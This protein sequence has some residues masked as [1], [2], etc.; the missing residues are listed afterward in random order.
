MPDTNYQKLMAN[1]L[2]EIA[3][4]RTQLTESDR[5]KKEP[6][7]IVG[8]GCRFP[9]G[10]NNVDDYWKLL[11]EGR[12][13]VARMN[14][15]RWDMD[16]G[17]DPDPAAPGKISSRYMGMLDKVDQFDADLFGI[18]PVEAQCMDPQHRIF[19]ET[20]WEALEHA[21]YAPDSL[22]GSKT[23][24]FLGISGQ[25]YAHLQT[26]KKLLD[27]I[28]PYDGT[29]NSSSVAAG[30]LSYLL[31]LT[32]PALAID[33]ACSSSLVVMNNAC[34][35]LR[36]RETNM[37]IAGGSHLILC[38]T[39]SI[40]FSKA[41]MLAEDGRCK[42]FDADANGYVRAE[43]CGVVILKRLSD[44]VKDGDNILALIRGTA[45][46]QDGRSQG[47][48]APNE[49]AQKSVIL[50]ALSNAGVAKKHVSYVE[51]HG[52]G[53][54]LGDP[55]EVDALGSVYSESHS[56]EQPLLIGSAKTN[57]GHMETAAGIGGIIKVVLSMQHRTLPA[58]QNYKTPNPHIQWDQYPIEVCSKKR[59]WKGYGKDSS[60]LIAGVSSFGFGGTNGHVILQSTPKFP[61]KKNEHEPDTH[62]VNLSGKS[63]KA[64]KELAERYQHFLVENPETSLANFAYT[65]RVGRNQF[66]H[67]ASIVA[68]S[69]SQLGEALSDF[70][71]N[72]KNENLVLGNPTTNNKKIAFFFSGQGSQYP[73][74]GKSLYDTQPKFRKTMDQCA[75]LLASHLPQPLFSVMWGDKTELLS[76]TQYTQPAL[77]AI[78][79]SLATL[80]R[81]WGIQPAKMLG[82]SVGEYAAACI[83]GIFTLE[84]A[85]K[86][87][88]ARGRLMTEL[89]TPGSMIVI[90]APEIAVQQSLIGLEDLV[91]I[92]AINGPSSVAV[93]GDNKT[94]E[95]LKL[96]FESQGIK[97]QPLTVSHAFHSPLMTPMLHAFS[98][99]AHSVEYRKPKVR[100]V[101]TL[102]G[103]QVK[104]EMSNADYWV[105]HIAAPVRFHKAV[106]S[107]YASDAPA[108]VIEIGPHTTLVGLASTF[109][110]DNTLWI[111]SLRKGKGD[112]PTLLNSIAKL[113]NTGLSIDWIKVENGYTRQRIALPTYPF[114][115]KT[116]WL[117][118]I[119]LGGPPD[120]KDQD[121]LDWIYDIDWKETKLP[122]VDTVETSGNFTNKKWLVMSSGNTL[123][124]DVCQKISDAGAEVVN[125]LFSD[126][127]EVS[128]ATQ[129]QLNPT[130]EDHFERLLYKLDE[131]IHLFEGI[132][133]IADDKQLIPV[134]NASAK[135][136]LSQQEKL[137]GGL[138]YLVQ[139]ITNTIANQLPKL[140]V[141]GDNTENAPLISLYQ[142]PLLG[143]T[144]VVA[145]EYHEL[146]CSSIAIS[147]P[148]A[149]HQL[150]QEIST[151]TREDQICYHN[152]TRSVARLK[153][154]DQNGTTFPHAS[155]KNDKTYLITG[156][157]GGLGLLFA[158]WLVQQGATSLSL[159]G[160]RG[161]TTEDQKSAIAALEATGARIQIVQLDISDAAAVNQLVCQINSTDK[162]LIGVIHTAG[163]L[164]DGVIAQQKWSRF[165]KVFQPKVVGT[166]NLHE[167]T[168]DLAL[169]HFILFSS[170]ASIL[171]L[172]G[173]SNYSAANTFLD[174]FAEYRRQLSQPVL[175]INWGPWSQTGMANKAVRNRLA[176][177]TGIGSIPSEQGIAIFN[178]LIDSGL[179]QVAVVP[180]DWSQIG[181]MFAMA[182]TTP[183]LLID[184][185][186]AK[187][188]GGGDGLDLSDDEL[189]SGGE[190]KHQL[191]DALPAERKKI[192][193]SYV[194]DQVINV[195][196]L[197]GTED[198]DVGIDTLQ[199]LHELG[200]DSLMAVEIRNVL[201]KAIS[202]S[203]PVGLLFD[204]PS[205]S[206]LAG[207]LD[208]QLKIESAS[209]A[210]ANAVENSTVTT[211][212]PND[213]TDDVDNDT[214]TNIMKHEISE[215][216][217]EL[218]NAVAIIGMACRYPG[219]ST[220]PAAFWDLLKNG[221]DGVEDLGDKRW[222]LDEYYDPDPAAPGKVYSR[223][224]GLIDDIDLFDN[225][226]F[227]IAPIEATSMDPQQRLLLETS[228]EAIEYAGYSPAS[229]SGN[230]GGVFVGAGPNE[231]GQQ[232]MTLA[233]PALIN[234]YLGTGNSLSIAAG[235]ISYVL[236]W[237][238]PCAAVDTACSS[239]LVSVHMACQSL[240]LGESD[241]AIAGGVNLT[242]SSLTNI[243]LSRAQ[244]LSADG[245]CKTF[246]KS[247]NGYV[248]SEGCGIVLLKRLK[249]AI[250][251]NDNILAVV[252]GSAINQDGRS[253]GLTAPNGP[254]QETV[255]STALKRAKV[256]AADIEY[257]EAH[258]TGT[259]LGD[260]IEMRSINSVY[261]KAKNRTTPLSVGSVKTNLGHTEVAAGAAGLIKIILSMKNGFIP[262]HLHLQE[263]S[264][265]LEF[266]KQKITIPTVLTPWNT[267]KKKRLAAISSF[268]FSGT[269][270]H[271][272][273]EEGPLRRA[274]INDVD[275]THHILTL[276]GKNEEALNAQVR[277]FQR[278]LQSNKGLDIADICY[279]ANVGRNHFSHRAAFVSDSQENLLSQ[280]EAFSL[281][282]HSKFKKL[283]G[284]VLFLFSG[285]GS[286]YPDMGK[287][288]YETH[289]QFRE[290]M[291]LCESLLEPHLDQSLLSVLWGEN[292]ALL[293]QTQY[294]QPALFAIEYSLAMLWRS[295]GV[296][297]DVLMGHSVGEYAAACIAGVFTLQD[298][299][300]MIAA[301]GRL[302]QQLPDNGSMIA[303]IAEIETVEKVIAPFASQVSIAAYNGP[304]QI[305]VSGE[306]TALVSITENLKSNGIEVIQL[307]VS[308]AFHS[309]LMEPMMQGFESVVRSV[310]FNKPRVG[311][312]SNL[313]G[314]RST[315]ELCNPQY[316][317]DHVRQ[318]VCFLQGMRTVERLKCS[319]LIEVGPRPTLLGMG[320]NCIPDLD[321]TWLPSLR[322]GHPEWKQ[323]LSAVSNMYQHG[324]DF[325]WTAFES[326]YQ[327]N[328]VVLPTYPFQRSR[329]WMGG[330]KSS[331]ISPMKRYKFPM[332]GERL[333]LPG[334][335]QVRFESTYTTS[336]PAYVTDH[337]LFGSV[338]VPGASHISLMLSAAN[339]AFGSSQC[340]L[341]DVCFLQP[342]VP[343][344]D[345]ARNVQLI[346]EIKDE[347]IAYSELMSIG[348]DEDPSDQNRWVVHATG[349]IHY[350]VNYDSIDGQLP[351]DEIKSE[352]SP[353]ITGE[354]FYSIFTDLGYN[355]GESFQWLGDGWYNGSRAVRELRWP[356]LPDAVKDYQLY[357]TLVD[358]FFQSLASCQPDGNEE[359]I[360]NSGNADEI[361]IPF[362]LER[363]KLYRKPE[364]GERLW[365]HSTLRDQVNKDHETQTG[366]VQL[367]DEN[368]KLV[369][370]VVAI[371]TRKASRAALQQGLNKDVVNDWLYQPRWHTKGNDNALPV[372]L[373]RKD[374]ASWLV[375]GKN[376]ASANK[377][378]HKFIAELMT[379]IESNALNVVFV[380]N[381][382]CYEQISTLRYQLSLEN[383][384]QIQQ[385]LSDLYGDS[386]SHCLGVINL[387]G[388]TEDNNID[389]LAALQNEQK[390]T[391]ESSIHVIQALSLM[392]WSK[393]PQLWLGTSNAY[394][395]EGDEQPPHVGQAALWGLGRVIAMEHA[396]LKCTRFDVDLQ[397]N[398]ES[399]KLDLDILIKDLLV[400]DN[401]DQ[402]AIRRGVRHVARLESTME[403]RH[404]GVHPIPA[405]EAYRVNVPSDGVLDNLS[406]D[407]AERIAP[408]AEEVE[409]RVHATALNFRDV[410]NALGMF[411]EFAERTGA[412]IQTTLPLGFDCAGEIV[413]IGKDVTNVKVGDTVLA[414]TMGSL[415]SHVVTHQ[416]FTVKKP[417]NISFAEAAAIPTVFL[418]VYY[419]LKTL[420]KIKKGDRVLIHACAGGVG[421]AA[422]QVAQHLGAEVFATASPGKW[423][424]LRAQGVKHIM[425][426]RTLEFADEI[427]T[428][429]NGEGVDIV[430]NS[431][432][433]ECIPKSLDLLSENGR[434]VEIGK[435]D[436]WSK[437]Q[438]VE[439]RPDVNYFV[440]DL[441]EIFISQPKLLALLLQE[442]ANDYQEGILKPLPLQSFPMHNVSS[443]FR[444][445]AQ[446][447]NIG[448]VV[449]TNPQEQQQPAIN[450]SDNS[451]YLI[452]GGLGALGLTV[453]ESLVKQGARH[454]VL[455]GR[456]SPSNDAQRQILRLET[457]GATVSV[458]NADIADE[459]N[460]RTLIGRFGKDFP[461]LGGIVHAAGVLDDGMI[462][463]QNWSRFETV[464]APKMLGAWHLH[465]QTE[466]QHSTQPLDFF[467]TFSSIASLMGSP[468]Q[469]NYAAANAFLDGLMTYR[470]SIGL[471]G[472][473]I[474]WGPWADIGMAAS[475]QVE[476]RFSGSTGVNALIPEKAIEAFERTL[477]N[478]PV[479]V[480]VAA[481]EWDKLLTNLGLTESPA[482]F[483]HIKIKKDNSSDSDIKKMAEVLLRNLEEVPASERQQILIDALCD[484]LARVMGFDTPEQID[485]QK[486]LQELG[487]DSLMAVEMR[488]IV[489]GF[490]G[491]ALPATLLFKYP[492]L[493]EL[494][495]F[496]TTELYPNHAAELAEETGEDI[497]E[498]NDI[499][500]PDE[501][502]DSHMLES[503]THVDYYADDV[504]VIETNLE[505]LTE[506]EAAELL[507]QKLVALQGGND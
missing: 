136:I 423:G 26:R 318:P 472:N 182:G 404:I 427:K 497:E 11:S 254:A 150:L 137:C 140:W 240:N 408:G 248:R 250:A 375:I 109:I 365:F 120:D 81:S 499:D 33:T 145:A 86:L 101:S 249:D 368:G 92:A 123:A 35:S 39:S 381:A 312:I 138:L 282:K 314:K 25:D 209:Q 89:T 356:K 377:L 40:V 112:W 341:D 284:D 152:G 7:A 256:S 203:L 464:L 172:P 66:N 146:K 366:D 462:T 297:P 345:E 334:S 20:T 245:R 338:V 467:I 344:D 99:I 70:I 93:S 386:G 266:D 351:W 110:D 83:A 157:L 320:R 187:A 221:V 463:Q 204:Y 484:Q 332:L 41:R 10:V 358:S 246:D 456:R 51:A 241:I 477:Q 308:H 493:M 52:T 224:G 34:Q 170:V 270:S 15:E 342:L 430:L 482:Y 168:K 207:H 94:I 507:A 277:N 292:T 220:N 1:A 202:M 251:D 184:Q 304:S 124:T 171:G 126:E 159:A 348:V 9:G 485:P 58:H 199:P 252:R 5:E 239:S 425:N 382:A 339:E 426:S 73:D 330:G 122:A 422:L 279:T 372:P 362:A 438:V 414:A 458:T 305:A 98:D 108:S 328:R 174:S 407:P 503:F 90:Q 22:A 340:E 495:G 331:S 116:F 435:I 200:L 75:A 88:A 91:T 302:M 446:A 385:L 216:T 335:K 195:M 167:A 127:W 189:N 237:Q 4:L 264:P 142:S 445:L 337:K 50:E 310:K 316:W 290:W 139:S 434:F 436:I 369:A 492:S 269:N 327:R 214:D 481:M 208:E 154:V 275:R 402:I 80:W 229:F 459:E 400:S 325:D 131:H 285:Q 411:K 169:D 180:M 104:D 352:W 79:Y 437:E 489:N 491:R 309:V 486:P 46:N 451:C 281:E 432:N 257:I 163:V 201:A 177:S 444:H 473:S 67:R 349:N 125:V 97:V 449:I 47:L 476:G 212:T 274:A 206:A 27:L 258:G 218:E 271:A 19:L 397:A 353:T 48:T 303:I 360:F 222:S 412:D 280:L 260:P 244:M 30:R 419:G 505:E 194:K 213:S 132:L 380:T 315:E 160:R 155:I 273:I 183:P 37:A 267:D 3:K 396:E 376:S 263:I 54:P 193:L 134:A 347:G 18:A 234:A 370:E 460:V 288:L 153:D 468:G 295:W 147:G 394:Q 179:H 343:S 65:T 300:K 23:G 105:K 293:N 448:K 28:S 480:G 181:S 161:I 321:A 95:S 144:K 431:I 149:T 226:F 453:A 443:G 416:Y 61:H 421:L 45:V 130:K 243:T 455:T 450:I 238:G 278:F 119:P 501:N 504:T 56:K 228:W 350:Q 413:A 466:R 176:R 457:L 399:R 71:D 24:V 236:G 14:K 406:I 102:I 324:L 262:P 211:E 487:L 151:V 390:E 367:I 217:P 191:G 323:I 391:C 133:F 114:Q 230:L 55:I 283:Q 233:D 429:T 388:L 371:E 13:G 440:F 113:S 319:I 103:E 322:N 118:H 175:T 364:A 478:N 498:D 417:K 354:E 82:H 393:P 53:T 336:S 384:D 502:L 235:R 44:A 156:G 313:T 215:D 359:F 36:S 465:Q 165:E 185:L 418:T 64:V 387:L 471:S 85:C 231:Y 333:R 158:E 196:G 143:L 424:F 379:E 49:S 57:L 410:L 268:G 2:E 361:Y 141:C 164:D 162:P 106:K 72:K 500:V 383:P 317:V 148:L 166:W 469:G 253:Q 225:D 289:Q 294:T 78:E 287:S 210:K 474:N 68:K 178:R 428:L 74:M 415:G 447:R 84:D 76:Q 405:T 6:I 496:L 490:L 17:F 121:R 128:S 42:T 389:N 227:G 242:L 32:G 188:G 111:P 299:L 441:T 63:T 494:S 21:G 506:E 190:L 117:D 329:F 286:Q 483:S 60:D 31:G 291:D 398:S 475:A 16:A 96:E 259:A 409:I 197:S 454:L 392:G 439:K 433:G 395:I 311:V 452:T 378:A 346:I 363:F 261:G 265:H 115:H 192:T 173:Q 219:H 296:S 479:Q 59:S 129:Y 69:V 29:G 223:W 298:G 420:A 198:G 43:G 77:F 357:P 373:K 186:A 326:S 107:L 461:Q 401:E 255:I 8:M 374:N 135:S 442:I 272:V 247:A 488:N 306:K 301:R 62:L 276:S 232:A 38:P 470:R 205:I 307:G 403:N 100:I 87:I 355:L 12:N